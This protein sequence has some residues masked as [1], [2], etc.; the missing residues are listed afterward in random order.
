MAVTFYRYKDASEYYREQQAHSDTVTTPL[1]MI[2]NSFYDYETLLYKSI[3]VENPDW[4]L[5]QI[6]KEIQ[7][8]EKEK[9]RNFMSYITSHK[10]TYRRNKNEPKV[11]DLNCDF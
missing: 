9:K 1:N 4:T 7:R 3:K 8:R 2:H 5:E 11:F 10:H 6:D